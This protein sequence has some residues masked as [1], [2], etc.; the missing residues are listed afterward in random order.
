MKHLFSRIVFHATLIWERICCRLVTRRR[1][2]NEIDQGVL[3]GAIPSRT[4]LERLHRLGVRSVVNMCAEYQLPAEVYD[5]YEMAALH[6]PTVDRCAPSHEDVCRAVAFI[7]RQRE[8]GDAVY[9]HCRAGRGRGATI[10][11]CWMIKSRQLTPQ[12]AYHELQRC[13]LQVDRDLDQR[14]VVVRFY[15][16]YATMGNTPSQRSPEPC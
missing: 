12:Q 5:Q 16:E 3:L 11:L 4:G 1:W 8:Q 6:L 9:I 13:R 15:K 2:W 10:A 14:D 7:S